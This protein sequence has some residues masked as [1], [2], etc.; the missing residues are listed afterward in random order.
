MRWMGHGTY[1]E[2]AP[3]LTAELDIHSSLPMHLP[4]GHPIGTYDVSTDSSSSTGDAGDHHRRACGAS[5]HRVSGR[6]S[7]GRVGLLLIA[8]NI[9]IVAL[10]RG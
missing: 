8:I 3:R 5:P 2:R 7:G 4:R 6:C 1:N 10:D 9:F